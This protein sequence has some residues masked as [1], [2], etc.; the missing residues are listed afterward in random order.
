MLVNLK[1]ISIND[2]KHLI[3]VKG[4]KSKIREY[5]KNKKY[6]NIK[7]CCDFLFLNYKKIYFFKF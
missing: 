4:G 2:K 1:D 7:Y 3:N 6:V 5:E